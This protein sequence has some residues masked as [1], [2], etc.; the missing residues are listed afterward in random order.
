MAKTNNLFESEILAYLASLT[1]EV[2]MNQ[3]GA[4]Q[5]LDKW[6]FPEGKWVAGDGVWFSSGYFPDK[7]PAKIR[8]TEHILTLTLA[9]IL[10]RENNKPFTLTLKEASMAC[11]PKK[12]KTKPK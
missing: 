6:M 12:P 9:S 1:H 2:A 7:T 5:L 8:E 10:A 3:P 4:Y 11:K